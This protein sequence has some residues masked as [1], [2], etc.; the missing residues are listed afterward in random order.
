MEEIYQRFLECG[1]KISTDTRNIQTGSVFFAL[2]GANFNGNL[3]AKKAL[4]SGASS[5]VVDED[6]DLSGDKVIKVK[7]CLETLQMLARHHRRKFSIPVIA[8]TGS[9]GKTTTKELLYHVLSQKFNTLATLGNLNNH[10]GV[11]LTLLRLGREHQVAVIEMGANHCHEIEELCKIAEPDI[12]IVTNIGKAHLEGF[13]GVEG[14]IKAKSEMFEFLKIG[15]RLS[16][17]NADDELL[18]NRSAEN[19]RILFGTG[20][21]VQLRG[22]KEDIYPFLSFS[23]SWKKGNENLQSGKIQSHLSGDFHLSNLLCASA[24]GCFMGLSVNE[25]KA[26]IESYKPTNQRSQ[27]VS[28]GKAKIML[29]TYNANPGSVSAAIKLM[30]DLPTTGKK[31]IVLGD[32]FELGKDSQDEHLAILKQIS[33]LPDLSAMVLGEEFSKAYMQSKNK[34]KNILHFTDRNV[35]FSAIKNT[36]KTN[37][38]VLLKGSRGMK[39]EEFLAA[40]N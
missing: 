2:K 37:L 35:L 13:G 14:V 17:V 15:K 18:M 1:Q 31:L 19:H 28:E 10:I 9:N 40:F 5:V 24:I 11:P 32:M 4:D 33:E 26:G 38:S 21:H 27:W 30:A 29:D 39:M 25:I 23:F 3:F 12:G 16:F 7:D 6:V 36:D 20:E 22:K 8:V 34:P